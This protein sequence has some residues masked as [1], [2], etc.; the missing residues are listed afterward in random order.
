MHG[1]HDHSIRSAILFTH[2]IG[3]VH[4]TYRIF[5]GLNRNCSTGMP[6]PML[7]ELPRAYLR[8]KQPLLVPPQQEVAPIGC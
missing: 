7:N 3:G 5:L 2:G 8:I 6:Q 4:K 1:S